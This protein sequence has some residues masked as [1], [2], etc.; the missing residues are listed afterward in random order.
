MDILNS[1]S[2]RLL[3]ESR[4]TEDTSQYLDAR[5]SLIKIREDLGLKKNEIDLAQKSIWP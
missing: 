3:L 2:L 1:Q 4:I 5:S